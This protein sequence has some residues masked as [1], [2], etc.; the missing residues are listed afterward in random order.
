MG[1]DYNS[2]SNTI[3]EYKVESQIG[4]GGS[5]K[6]FKVKNISS[7]KF[8]AKKIFTEEFYETSIS[9][10]QKE[11]KINKL[12][13][14]CDSPYILKYISSN[15]EDAD[16]DEDEYESEKYIILE[17][18]SK[19]EIYNYLKFNET[20]LNDENCKLI[21]YKILKALQVIHGKGICH[22]DLDPKNIFLDGERYEIK[23]GDFGLSDFFY[24]KN[25]NKIFLKGQLGK[26]T[27]MAPEVLENRKY[28]EKI[29]IFSLGVTLFVLRTYQKPFCIAIA[30]YKGKVVDKLYAY[31]KDKDE[32]KYWKELP[33]YIKSKNNNIIIFD[34]QFK[35]L[36]F[37]MV[38]YNPKERPTIEEILNHPY[39]EE[40]SHANKDQFKIMEEKLIYELNKRKDLI[41]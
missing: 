15:V 39:I 9:D 2:N 1:N 26:S 23:V 25:G 20:G 24:D 11:I 10:I 34:S 12:L 31:I 16:L 21:I 32:E 17:L 13:S 28:D 40:V 7:G 36:F 4:K 41:K 19:G 38:A 33:K 14:A 30:T 22:R 6:V 29:D 5:S 37:K 3:S 27:F 18:A 35:D 8:Y